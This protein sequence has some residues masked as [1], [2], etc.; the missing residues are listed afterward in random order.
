VNAE[1]H[2]PIL[3][4]SLSNSKAVLENVPSFTSAEL[5]PNLRNPFAISFTQTNDDRATLYVRKGRYILS[6]LLG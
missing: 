3:G 1:F 4:A 6:G 2:I 5:L